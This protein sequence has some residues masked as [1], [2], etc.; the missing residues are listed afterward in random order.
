MLM[1]SMLFSECRC[2]TAKPNRG[3]WFGWD[4]TGQIL[5]MIQGYQRFCCQPGCSPPILAKYSY[6]YQ[7]N[8]YTTFFFKLPW[9][10]DTLQTN[11]SAWHLEMKFISLHLLWDSMQISLVYFWLVNTSVLWV[12]NSEGKHILYCTEETVLNGRDTWGNLCSTAQIFL[13]DTQ[14]KLQIQLS[15][16]HF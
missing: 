1:V 13:P 7:G 8:V 3:L 5:F 11:D 6:F 10:S 4:S 12:I 14:E 9:Y 15:I 16:M 2:S